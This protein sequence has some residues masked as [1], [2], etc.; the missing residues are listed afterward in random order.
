MRVHPM[1]LSISDRGEDPE[2]TE[3][4]ELAALAGRARDGA[5]GAFDELASRVR[6]RVRRW[7]RRMVRDA[8]DAEDVAQLVL[9]RIHARLG[10]F[11][12]RGRFTTWLYRVT[13]NVALD[14]RRTEE[15]RAALRARERAYRAHG[16]G[17]P[18]WEED[19]ADAARVAR[20]V[21]AY[22]RQLPA[23]QRQVF[24]LADLRGHSSAEIAAALGIEPATVRVT[25]L[26]ARRAIRSRILADHPELMEE[27]RHDL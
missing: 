18:A 14:R 20:L 24:E 1:E 27:Y 22:F 23:R 11:G 16:A 7:A 25:L 13:R 9:L 19:A 12:G 15:R 26:K 8:D 3:L 21:H 6:E 10:E 5:P 4:A 2:L 17:A